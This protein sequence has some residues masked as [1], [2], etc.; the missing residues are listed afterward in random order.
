[1]QD[2][3]PHDFRRTGRTHI[4]GLGVRDE[5]AEALLNHAKEQVNGTYNLYTS[6]QERKDALK[7][8]HA[9][10]EGLRAQEVQ[11]GHSP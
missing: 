3:R 6:W 8:W 9:K 11:E 10:L 7:L 4:S 2:I 5:V 1:L